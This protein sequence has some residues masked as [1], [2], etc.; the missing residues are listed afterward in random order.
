MV[1]ERKFRD[2]AEE[3][4]AELFEQSIE[5]V[6]MRT[7]QVVLGEVV[8]INS[9]IVIVNAGLK[10]EAE[11]PLWQFKDMTGA[12]DIKIGDKV[13]VEIEAVEDGQ[14]RTRLSREK[15]CRAKAWA[16][17]EEAFNEQTVVTGVL[18]S[19]VKG[20]FTVSI[21]NIRGFLPGSLYGT[22]L[23]PEDS[24]DFE[25]DTSPMEFK[26][27]KLDRVRNNV[28]VSRRAVLEKELMAEREALLESLEE[29]QVLNG[30]VKNIT[31][32]GAFI[33]LGGIDGLLH[34]TDMSWHRIKH[35]S[36]VVEIGQEVT[37]KVLNFNREESRI[38]LGLKQLT[39]DPWLEIQ[40]RYKV[41]DRLVSRVASIVDYGVFVEL[42]DFIKG[43]VHI[44]EMDWSSRNINPSEICSIGDEVEVE[45][46]GV[47]AERHRISLGMKQC[48]PNP[49]TA[50]AE[51]HEV[52][53]RIQGQIK[54]LTDFGIFVSLENGI[55]GLVHVNDISWTKDG[56]D[57][58]RNFKKEEK[59]EVAV[60]AIDAERER[61]SLGL[62]QLETDPYSHYVSVNGKGAIVDCV[63][64]AIKE[65]GVTV[66]LDE[67]V[68]GFIRKSELSASSA[69]ESVG[70]F[71]EG[72]EVQAKIT[73]IDRKNRKIFL[74]IRSL[75]VDIQE[76][77]YEAV[78]QSDPKPKSALASQL[79]EITTA[80]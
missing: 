32:Y 52:G 4:F 5:N 75:E 26:V 9:D 43:L 35:S 59:I 68:F 64:D 48:K 13:D 11:I 42:N 39:E 65:K 25:L 20:G 22:K 49:W 71:T 41:G 19:R 76:E 3:S 62:K 29:G 33:N 60:L 28:V 79:Q 2:M 16:E 8:D 47:D 51:K 56:E 30:T 14:G 78:K 7:G 53:D 61:I 36:E 18:T 69:S 54:S 40:N 23:P 66:K 63:I 10:S 80:S 74:S 57:E 6:E 46:L 44:S 24:E 70:K 27:I 34:I 21:S 50:F 55:D 73:S 67:G 58:I 38:S 45:V 1:P 15:A 17:I 31:G 37:V 77:A 12:V 72:Q